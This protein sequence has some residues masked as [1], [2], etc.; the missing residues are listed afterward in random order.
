MGATVRTSIPTSTSLALTQTSSSWANKKKDILFIRIHTRKQSHE[1]IKVQ[2]NQDTVATLHLFFNESLHAYRQTD[3]QTD[4]QI[5]RHTEYA[6][7]S[8]CVCECVCECVR[9]W[10]SAC[11]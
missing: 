9:M 11:M 2:N 1:P 8:A 6:H 4:R 3:R 10:V 7:V 5:D